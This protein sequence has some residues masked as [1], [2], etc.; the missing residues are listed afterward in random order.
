MKF[1]IIE[2]NKVVNVVCAGSALNDSWVELVD[3]FGIGDDYIAECGYSKPYASPEEIQATYLSQAEKAVD[4]HIL[5][6]VNLIGYD[7]ENSIAKYMARSTSPWYAES[8]ALGDW[9]DACWLKCH[10]LLNAG[11]M[12]PI[13]DLIAAL[14]DYTGV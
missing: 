6:Q 11:E 12:I 1:A 10:E 4:A 8:I 3:G 9:I 14:P 7:N 2:N 13:P 5:N